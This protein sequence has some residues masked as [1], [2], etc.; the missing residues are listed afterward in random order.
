MVDS[1]GESK[2]LAGLGLGHRCIHRL[3]LISGHLNSNTLL[4]DADHRI[5]IAD[6]C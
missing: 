6:L 4:F 5:Q 2:E 1:D 3:G